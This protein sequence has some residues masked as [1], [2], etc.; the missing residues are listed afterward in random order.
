MDTIV[1]GTNEQ[2]NWDIIEESLPEHLWFHLNSFPSP[3][4]IIRSSDPDKSTIMEAARICKEKSKYSHIRS[5]KVV[6]TTI[7]NINLSDKVGCV[8]I[9]SKRKCTCITP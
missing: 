8:D 9:V 7:S 4:V 5:I 3:H 2:N 6:Y 1:V